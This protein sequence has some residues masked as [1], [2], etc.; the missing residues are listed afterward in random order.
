[1]INFDGLEFSEC[2]WRTGDGSSHE[3]QT[4][5]FYT[6]SPRGLNAHLSLMGDVIN[7]KSCETTVKLHTGSIEFHISC[8]QDHL[9]VC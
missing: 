6:K 8:Y 7:Y 5:N 9:E 3:I 1:M 4:R 2:H